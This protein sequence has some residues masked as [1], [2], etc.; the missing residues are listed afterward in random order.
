MVVRASVLTPRAAH[1]LPLRRGAAAWIVLAPERLILPDE[2]A[3]EILKLVDG[4]TERRRHHRRAGRALQ[5]RRA[6]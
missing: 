1:R 3:V 6:S 4:K 2:K 5:R